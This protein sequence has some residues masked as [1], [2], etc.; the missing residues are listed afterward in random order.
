MK[1]KIIDPDQGM[2]DKY[3]N[4]LDAKNLPLPSKI[5]NED[6]DPKPLITKVKTMIYNSEKYISTNST[7]K[8]KPYKKVE[9]EPK[10]NI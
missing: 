6:I 2:S 5:I 10:D 3:K 7:T 4:L 8:G 9:Q 1:P